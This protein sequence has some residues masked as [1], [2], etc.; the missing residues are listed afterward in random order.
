MPILGKA[1][2][3]ARNF[4]GSNAGQALMRTVSGLIPGDPYGLSLKHLRRRR[5]KGRWRIRRA[6]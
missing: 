5:R 6:T 1:A 4:L 2:G 3:T